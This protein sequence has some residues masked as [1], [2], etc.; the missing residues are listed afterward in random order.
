M[1]LLREQLGVRTSFFDVEGEDHVGKA[2]SEDL[3]SGSLSDGGAPLNTL[4]TL[5]FLYG[6]ILRARLPHPSRWIRL[7]EPSPWPVIVFGSPD[8]GTS[9][10]VTED[11]EDAPAARPE[12]VG[13]AGKGSRQVVFSPIATVLAAYQE[14]SRGKLRES[15]EALASR[16][17]AELPEPGKP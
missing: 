10:A 4:I 2:L 15:S 16:C 13:S 17:A 7:K 5:G 3:G 11:V 9:A 12:T 14:R 6:E 8:P 1:H